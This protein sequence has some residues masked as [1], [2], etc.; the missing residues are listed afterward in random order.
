MRGA[1]GVQRSRAEGGAKWDW[2]TGGGSPWLTV[3][4]PG[5]CTNLQSE[6]RGDNIDRAFKLNISGGGHARISFEVLEN[7]DTVSQIVFPGVFGRDTVEPTATP[8][9]CSLASSHEGRASRRISGK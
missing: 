6:C 7:T 8:K 9:Y 2:Q 3:F 1:D 5:D 4:G